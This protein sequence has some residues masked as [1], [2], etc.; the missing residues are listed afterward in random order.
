MVTI[1][2]EDELRRLA[3]LEKKLGIVI[4]PKVLYRGRVMA[5]S[6]DEEGAD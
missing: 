3:R 1:G 2:D 5:P 6:E 4:Y